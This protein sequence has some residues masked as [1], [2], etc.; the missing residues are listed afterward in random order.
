[1]KLLGLSLQRRRTVQ[2]RDPTTPHTPPLS[3]PSLSSC[4]NEPITP[5]VDAVDRFPISSSATSS[6]VFT[7]TQDFSGWR[8]SPAAHGLGFDFDGP[9][10]TD[11]APYGGPWARSGIETSSS[12]SF[13][14]AVESHTP[15]ATPEEAVKSL[16]E[17]ST[18]HRK[19]ERLGMTLPSQS[20]V[21]L[22]RPNTLQEL[23]TLRQAAFELEMEDA[24]E[25]LA[26]LIASCSDAASALGQFGSTSAQKG[27]PVPLQLIE[28]VKP[29]A[30]RPEPSEE[31]RYRLSVAQITPLEHA[32][33]ANHSP[34][35]DIDVPA[36]RTSFYKN[37]SA[38][39][40]VFELSSRLRSLPRRFNK[41]SPP[42][43]LI[44]SPTLIVESDTESYTF[45]DLQNHRSVD[46]LFI[47]CH[48]CQNLPNR[49]KKPLES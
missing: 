9:S 46:V 11:T 29:T 28:E 3:S 24:Q 14:T 26:G 16:A 23:R 13:T 19:L 18:N 8:K 21:D 43:M 33:D 7:P 6:A 4:E 44:S 25:H 17:S 30:A 32:S 40:S 41:A 39:Q 37:G 42:V 1:M 12:S 47:L 45:W 10:P 49:S 34:V 48:L 31:P 2:R 5:G 38:T 36:Q 35:L 20:L 27:V 22:S 15:K